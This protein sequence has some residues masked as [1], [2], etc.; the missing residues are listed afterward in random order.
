MNKKKIWGLLACL[1]LI[2]CLEAQAATYRLALIV[3]NNEGSD[4]K[5]FLR[6]AEQDARNLYRALNDVGELPASQ[7]Q[8]HLGKNPQTILNAVRSLQT[9][10]SHLLRNSQ[11]HL[12]FIFYFSGHSDGNLMEMGPSQL[13]FTL[14]HNEISKIPSTVRLIILDTCHSG[15]M[16]QTKGGS[17]VPP[18]SIPADEPDLPKGEIIITSSTGLEDS[19]ESSELQGSFFT[20]YF[21]SGLRGAADFNLDGKVSLTE[22]YSFA[23][24]KTAAKAIALHKQQNPTY[25]FD[26]SGTGEIFLSEI[27]QGAPLLYLSPPEAGD[28]L[29]YEKGS[30]NLLAEIPK[31][32][33][34]PRYVALPKGEL[35]I[36]KRGPDYY[37]EREITANPGGI[38][39]FR[40]EEGKRVRIG[41]VRRILSYD[42]SGNGGTPVTLREGEIVRLRLDETLSSKTSQTGDKIRMESAEDVYV[43]GRLA[44]SAGAPAR[45]EILALRQKRGLVHGELICRLG[46]IQAVDGQWIPLE[47]LISR[48]SSGLKTI[49]EGTEDSPMLS[50]AGSNMETD[51][52]SSLTAV[53]F[54]PFYPFLRGRDAVIEEGTFFEAFVARDTTIR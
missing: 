30:R 24:Q 50:S 23:N 52:A 37:V 36:R 39:Y 51:I 54:L 8:L 4:T 20:H 33:G 48:G 14:L 13:D 34:S 31:T 53:F 42:Q 6:Y 28:F 18:L 29:I 21:V 5:P 12:L 19:L 3:G 25:D 7:M 9:Q 43:N 49:S 38:Y 45:G 40:E 35:L 15:H 46:Y 26:L 32:A 44:I 10:A 27:M 41:S 17:K 2:P 16:I 1:L 47:S 11:D 22:V